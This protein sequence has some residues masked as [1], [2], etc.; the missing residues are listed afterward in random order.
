MRHRVGLDQRGRHGRQLYRR[1]WGVVR[2]LGLGV[3]SAILVGLLGV[4]QL[5][6]RRRIRELLLLL[7][8]LG[9]RRV[10]KLLMLLM[11]RLRV[12]E[13]WAGFVGHGV[14][15]RAAGIMHG[16]QGGRGRVVLVHLVWMCVE[17]EEE[18]ERREGER[19]GERG[20]KEERRGG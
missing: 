19:R 10:L 12:A 4:G 9:V 1:A 18:D 5:M 13:E 17:E 7:R 11:R 16:R 8:V 6:R 3:G 2:A 15:R 14:L 20:K